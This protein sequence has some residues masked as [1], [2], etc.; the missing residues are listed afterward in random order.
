VHYY[1][2]AVFA[3]LEADADWG[4]ARNTWGTAADLKELNDNMD[5][6]KKNCVDKGMPLIVGEYAACGN[7]KT[8]EMK[9]LYAVSVTEAVY[10]RRMCPMLWDTSGDQYNRNTQTFRDPVFLE[11]MMAIPAKY[12]RSTGIREVSKPDIRMY[13]NPVKNQLTVLSEFDSPT[14]LSFADMTGRT[15]KIVPITGK[16]IDISNLKAGVYIVRIQSQ[17]MNYTQKLVI[18]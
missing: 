4:K 17:T 8:Q 14:T 7:N 10:A 11:E 6:L 1:T 16:A 2:P 13:P 18:E 15:A 3:I 5:L 9:R 12:P